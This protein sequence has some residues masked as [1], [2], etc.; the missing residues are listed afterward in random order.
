MDDERRTIPVAFDGNMGAGALACA[1]VVC[2]G[3]SPVGSERIFA[4]DAVGLVDVALTMTWDAPPT[5]RMVFGVF[6]CEK[7]ACRSDADLTLIEYA[8]GTSPLAL[9]LEGVKV[10]EAGDLFVFANVGPLVS[11][12]MAYAS[13]TTPRAFHVEGTLVEAGA[14]PEQA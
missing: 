10:A 3:L 1:V 6:T 4:T 8:Y 12:G 13:L 5:E 2:Q 9:E 14:H 7:D 11:G